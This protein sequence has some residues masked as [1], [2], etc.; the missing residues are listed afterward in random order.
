MGIVLS[1]VFFAWNIML[2]QSKHLLKIWLLCHVSVILFFSQPFQNRLEAACNAYLTA[3]QE[4]SILEHLSHP[5]IVPFLGLA[6]HP[7]SLV[8]GLAPH[9]SLNSLL[10]Q[11]HTAGRH[12]PLFAVRQVLLQVS[13][14]WF[15]FS[16]A[17]RSE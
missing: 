5:H 14:H 4:V 2:N 9:G 10:K 11:F 3:R 8:L 15:I 1:R 17:L 16:Q 6:L 12:L 13:M 7:L